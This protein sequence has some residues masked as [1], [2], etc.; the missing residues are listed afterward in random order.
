LVGDSSIQTVPVWVDLNRVSV[1]D[2]RD[3]VCERTWCISSPNSSQV[4][5]IAASSSLVSRSSLASASGSVGGNA[6]AMLSAFRT[7]RIISNTVRANLIRTDLSSLVPRS[8]VFLLVRICLLQLCT[9][10]FGQYLS[11]FVLNAL[12]VGVQ[13]GYKIV[14]EVIV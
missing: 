13:L 5:R 7:Y 9:V 11:R 1:K 14:E 6:C 8:A 10:H 3:G 12:I 2:T 4:L